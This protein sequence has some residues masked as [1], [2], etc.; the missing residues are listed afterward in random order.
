MAEQKISIHSITAPAGAADGDKM[1]VDFYGGNIIRMSSDTFTPRPEATYSNKLN[2]TTYALGTNSST[3]DSTVKKQGT[4]ALAVT[5]NGN[6]AR[7]PGAGSASQVTYNDF[8]ISLWFYIETFKQYSGGL[9]HLFNSN[10]KSIS[11]L[12]FGSVANLT[13]NNGQFWFVTGAYNGSNYGGLQVDA[14]TNA[15]VT[16]TWYH[17]VA[18]ASTTGPSIFCYVTEEGQ[19]FGNKVSETTFAGSGASRVAGLKIG[20]SDGFYLH[21]SAGTASDGGDVT[22][23]DLRIYNTTAT[24]T[25][26][27]AIFN[28]AGDVTAVDNPLQD[29]LKLAYTFDNTANSI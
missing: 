18:G 15:F 1:A 10:D 25:Q 7:S 2:G 8:T 20:G 14:G 12:S 23:D 5:G 16:D 11:A 13:R 17:M 29:N 27:E 28:S 26:A 24:A 6:S 19:S 4:H 21:G 22:Y 9:V 3:Y